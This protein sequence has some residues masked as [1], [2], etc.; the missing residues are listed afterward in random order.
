MNATEKSRCS[1]RLLLA[2]VTGLISGVA[3]TIVAWILDH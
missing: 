3:R 1:Y 2:V